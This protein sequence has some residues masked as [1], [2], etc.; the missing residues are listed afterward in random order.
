MEN[1]CSKCGNQLSIGDK[2]CNK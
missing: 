1:F 2:F